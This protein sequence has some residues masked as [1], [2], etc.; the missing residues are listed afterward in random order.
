VVAP[1]VIQYQVPLYRA[2]AQHPEID[3]TVLFCSR[4]GS[5]EYFD[6][7][8]GRR[9]SWD[10]PLGEGYEHRFFSNW[11]AGPS[12]GGFFARLNPGLG[13]HLLRRRYDAVVVPGYATAS[14]W[15]AYLAAWLRGMP[16]LFRGEVA[17]R[18]SEPRWLRRIKRPLIGLLFRG[19]SGFLA[20]GRAGR[21][22]YRSYG[23]PEE[24]VFDTPYTVDND[25][26]MEEADRLR[27][28]RAALREELGLPLDGP[29]VAFVGKLVARKRPL[30]LVEAAARLDA[31]PALLFVGDGVLRP[32]LEHRARSL[33]IRHVAF[34]GFRNQSEI[35]RCYAAADLLALPSSHEVAPLVLNEAMCSG[36]GLVVSDAV[37]SAADLVEDGANGYVHECG[38]ILA[39]AEA[40][41]AALWSPERL[42]E[43]GEHSRAK[44]ARRSHAEAVEGLVKALCRCSSQKS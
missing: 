20:I 25:F 14:Y 27:P 23:V 9:L 38:H 22:F 10:L 24:R 33:G 26:F 31:P 8:F 35:P 12:S 29:V 34:A 42:R 3:L 4:A 6:R 37:P 19:T 16:V 32:Q 13:A 2:L 21:E 15:I 18:A 39:L 11:S 5:N 43:L 1:H 41:R 40:L 7:E 17:L 30:D 44:I 36:L 28:E